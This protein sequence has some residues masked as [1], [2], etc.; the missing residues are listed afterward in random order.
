MKRSPRRSQLIHRFIG[1]W[2]G[3]SF[4]LTGLVL[5]EDEILFDLCSGR[6]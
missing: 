6:D 5:G 3:F 4:D 2:L 1:R